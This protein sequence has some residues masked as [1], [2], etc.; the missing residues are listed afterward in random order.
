MPRLTPR[1]NRRT[2]EPG[3]RRGK[4]K[5]VA[6]AVGWLFLPFLVFHNP[7]VLVVTRQMVC[8]LRTG[9]LNQTDRESALL[10]ESLSQ[11]VVMG[12]N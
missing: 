4:G 7:K 2:A 5:G 1:R 11:D 3:R 8:F 6:Y 10:T 9:V 12:I